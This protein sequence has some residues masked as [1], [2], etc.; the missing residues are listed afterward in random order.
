MHDIP[1]FIRFFRRYLV[2]RA[3]TFGHRFERAKDIIVAFLTVKR[4]KYSTSFLNTT[5]FLLAFVVLVGGPII[6]ENNPF[7]SNFEDTEGVYQ[8]AVIAYNPEQYSLQTVLSDKPRD[9]VEEYEVEDGDTLA[10]I[11]EKFDVTTDT[12]RWEND[13]DGDVIKPGQVLRIPPVTGVVHEVASGDSVYS[14]A[15]KYDT[16]AQAIVNFPFNDFTDLDTFQLSPGQELYVPNGVIEAEQ[17]TYTQPA[18]QTATVAQIQGGATGGGNFIWPTDGL[19][20]QYPVWYHMA[21]DIA[22]NSSPPI[23][24]A[25]AGVVSYSGCIGWGYGCHVI[26]DHNNGFQTLYAHLSTLSV[27]AG[28]SVGQGQQLGLMGST[29]RST[30]PHLHFEIRSGGALQNPLG[31]L[32]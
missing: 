26:V 29:G 6:A 25:D 20:T 18:G 32:N 27:S 1:E 10:S 17:D 15:D 13:I 11:A 4:G 3:V 9:K 14:I 8:A 2:S 5:F 12:I 31:Y 7:I 30:G 19:I 21:L 22:S 28:Q 23:L 16:T 24:A